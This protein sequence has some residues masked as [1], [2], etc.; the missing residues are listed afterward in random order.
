MTFLSKYICPPPFINVYNVLF[1]YPP[2]GLPVSQL[3]SPKKRCIF[4]FLK[5]HF[6]LI[7]KMTFDLYELFLIKACLGLPISE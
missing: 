6:G 3:L 2:A 7:S 4:R 5:G 1:D